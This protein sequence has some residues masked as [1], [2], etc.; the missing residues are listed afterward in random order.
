MDKLII[1]GAASQAEI[2]EIIEI[3]KTT[4]GGQRM[5][6]IISGSG[7]RITDEFRRYELDHYFEDQRQAEMAKREMQE[8]KDFIAAKSGKPSRHNAIFKPTFGVRKSVTKFLTAHR[9]RGN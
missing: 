1:V 5:G 2:N 9:K 3:M 7:L 8:S 4:K 6:V